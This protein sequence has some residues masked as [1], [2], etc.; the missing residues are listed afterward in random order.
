MAEPG[1]RKQVQ[2]QAV[3]LA[4]KTQSL[5]IL[6]AVAT[7]LSQPGGLEQVLDG[8]LDTFIELVDARAASVRLVAEGGGTRLI[9]SRGLAPEVVTMHSQVRIM[10]PDTEELR[11]VSLVYPGEE[12]SL[13]G[14]VS[15]FTHLGTAL[16][17][18]PEGARMDWQTPDGRTKSVVVLEVR[19]QPEAHGLDHETAPDPAA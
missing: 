15:V 1:S 4:R 12:D 10:D 13:L 17:G 8:F 6:Y 14:K 9:A 16:L 11:T 7:S 2:S 3:R 19:Y 5:D 18:L